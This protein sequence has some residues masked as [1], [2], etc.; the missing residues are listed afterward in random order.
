MTPFTPDELVRFVVAVD[1]HLSRRFPLLMIGGSAARLAYRVEGVTRDIDTPTGDYEELLPAFEAA[2]ADTGL[3]IPLQHVGVI[4][5]PYDYESRLERLKHPSL[6]NLQ[7]FVPEKHDLVLM[8]TVRGQEP[9][10]QTAVE[11]KANVG[12]DIDILIS[13]YLAEVTQATGDLRMLD[14][15]F[16]T[17]IHRLYGSEAQ[18]MAKRELAQARSGPPSA[19]K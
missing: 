14:L 5:P 16:L 12:L 7:I 13:R 2:R 15:N 8:K 17:L 10:L 9:D 19:G 11:M 1:T 6:E 4:D 18:A 3:N